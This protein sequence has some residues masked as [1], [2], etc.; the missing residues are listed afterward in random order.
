M[1]L[2][3]YYYFGKCSYNFVDL[4]LVKYPN[5]F[6]MKHNSIANCS[7]DTF[8]I[9]M[10]AA[11]LLEYMGITILAVGGLIHYVVNLMQCSMH[12]YL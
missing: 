11:D 2:Y 3:V 1:I 10:E 8:D 12:G 4:L 9:N 5:G 6:H 7:S